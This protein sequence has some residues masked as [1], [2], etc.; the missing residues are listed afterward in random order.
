MIDTVPQNLFSDG[1]S[2]QNL[3]Y[4]PVTQN[5]YRASTK[6]KYGSYQGTNFKSKVTHKVAYGVEL[7]F[8]GQKHTT[9][10]DAINIALNY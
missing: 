7:E 5:L 6:L 8:F 3:P 2:H 10:L 1:Y 9:F 4:T